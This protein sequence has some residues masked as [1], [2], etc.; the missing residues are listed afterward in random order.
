MSTVTIGEDGDPDLMIDLSVWGGG[1]NYRASSAEA[2][3][4]IFIEETNKALNLKDDLINEFQISE[5]LKF[6]AI[7]DFDFDEF[8]KLSNYSIKRKR[9][10][11]VLLYVNESYPFLSRWNYG[12][13]NVNYL[14]VDIEG[15]WSKDLIDSGFFSDFLNKLFYFE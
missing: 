1:R 13:G 6:D 3:P 10:S 5:N 4:E 8:P 2:I 9:N 15:K 11:E 12:L 7:D 14:G